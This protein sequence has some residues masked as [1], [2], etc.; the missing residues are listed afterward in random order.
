MTSPKD[1]QIHNDTGFS[2]NNLLDRGSL[3]YPSDN[4]YQSV[5]TM[6]EIFI[7]IDNHTSLSRRF[8]EGPCRR[9]LVDISLLEIERNSSEI[10]RGWCVC[11]TSK[12]EILKKLFTT[13]ANCILSKK[14][15]KLITQSLVAIIRNF[16]N[17][18]P[19][20]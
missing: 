15:K 19:N 10:W 6:Y 2:L 1:I 8:Y 3:K 20:S 18:L 17:W 11:M 9:K 12:W 5:V 14:V 13:V 7:K 4:V 16:R